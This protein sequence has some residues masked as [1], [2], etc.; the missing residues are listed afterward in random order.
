MGAVQMKWETFNQ[1]GEL[2]MHTTTWGL[3]R[4]RER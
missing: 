2:V 1:H 4:K 3:L